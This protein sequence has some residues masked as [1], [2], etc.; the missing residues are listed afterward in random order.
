MKNITFITVAALLLINLSGCGGSSGNS[1]SIVRYGYAVDDYVIGGTV[2]FYDAGGAIVYT[3]TTKDKGEF[4]WPETISGSVKI[5]ITGGLED[6]DG[7]ST[8]TNDQRAFQNTLSAM[9]NANTETAPIVVSAVSTGLTYAAAGD[10]QKYRALSKELPADIFD[11]FFAGDS[12]NKDNIDAR[13]ENIKKIQRALTFTNIVNEIADDGQLNNS[14]S[15]SISAARVA[16]SVSTTSLPISVVADIALQYCVAEALDKEPSTITMADLSSI[17]RLYCTDAN[18]SSLKGIETMTSLESLSL[19]DNEI[20]DAKPITQLQHLYYLNLSGNRIT[21]VSDL[22]SG[23]YSGLA[24]EIDKNCIQD[25]GSLVDSPQLLISQY[26]TQDSKQF[27]GCAKND[28]DVRR[29]VAKVSST[30]AYVLTYMATQNALADCKID[31]GDGAT[32]SALCDARAHTLQHTYAIKP[33]NPVIFKIN[34]I[35]KGSASFTSASS[36]SDDFSGTSLDTSKWVVESLGGNLATLSMSGGYLNINVPGGSCG[37][38]GTSDGLRLKP[39]IDPLLGDFVMELSAEEIARASRD[40]SQPIS[41][42]QLLLVGAAAQ[43]GIYVTGDVNNNQGTPGHTIYAYYLNGG[44][45]TYPIVKSLTIGQYYALK[46]R[47]RRAGGLLYLGYMI[48]QD[49]TWNEVTVP[50][51]FPSTGGYTPSIVVAS[52][53]GG[54]TRVNSSFKARFDYFSISR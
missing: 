4:S 34:G 43:A 32:E 1:G 10:L 53:D 37:Y 11:K 25:T 15:I 30:G 52:G 27:P 20:T 51:S 22:N 21:T 45:A 6:A 29:I 50:A 24:L 48:P 12:E 16:I 36:L 42:I 7:I 28:A 54:G 8:T 46:F 2:K 13:L 5:E 14:N 39:K 41:N 31:W 47:I 9:V 44:A 49:T 35:T 19:N 33:T 26:I 3:T 40:S 23:A 38:C 18:V 17:T